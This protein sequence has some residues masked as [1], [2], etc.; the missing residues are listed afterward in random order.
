ML[1]T[2]GSGYIGSHTVVE[3]LNEGY[4]AIIGQEV[5]NTFFSYFLV[6][7]ILDCRILKIISYSA[8]PVIAV[9]W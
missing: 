3:L 1:V 8:G 7:E 2:G 4:D 5:E 9:K 6:D